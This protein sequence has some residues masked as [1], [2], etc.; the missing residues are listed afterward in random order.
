MSNHKAMLALI[1]AT[2][3]ARLVRT[4]ARGNREPESR[5]EGQRRNPAVDERRYGHLQGPTI[6]RR[7]S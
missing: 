5:S 2:R 6:Q 3:P 1:V 7:K 4:F